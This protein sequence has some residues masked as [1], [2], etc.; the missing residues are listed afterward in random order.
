MR[1][2]LN[3][4]MKIMFTMISSTTSSKSCPCPPCRSSLVNVSVPLWV[5]FE[6]NFA[7]DSCAV[8]RGPKVLGNVGDTDSSR[9][10]SCPFS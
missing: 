4:A 6:E 10:S 8:Q 2:H 5:K 3:L 1:K 9:T 7:G